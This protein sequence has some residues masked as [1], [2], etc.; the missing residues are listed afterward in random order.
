MNESDLHNAF[1]RNK[2]NNDVYNTVGAM[3]ELKNFFNN[4][5]MYHLALQ[6]TCWIYS[7]FPLSINISF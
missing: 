6:K 1:C 3:N 4:N 5:F 7:G 2:H